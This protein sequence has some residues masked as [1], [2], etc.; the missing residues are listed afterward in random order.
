MKTAS[1]VLGI[2]GGVLAII[3]AIIFIGSGALVGSMAQ[4][5]DELTAQMEEEGWEVVEDESVSVLATDVTGAAAGTLLF[6]GIASIIGAAMGIVGGAL[7]KKKSI[8]AGI[9]MLVAAIPSF[10]T[11]L[12]IIASV[13][14]IIGGIM[15]L[16]PQKTEQKAA[17]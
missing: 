3:F 1:L 16:I 14:F 15:A 6:I 11:G 12:G 4:G 7:A 13:L 17:V 8:I 10:F 9:L 5:I 2:I